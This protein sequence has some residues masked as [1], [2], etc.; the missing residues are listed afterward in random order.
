M[1]K[2]KLI[3]LLALLCVGVSKSWAGTATESYVVEYVGLTVAD[4]AGYDIWREYSESGW[5]ITTYTE[6]IDASASNDYLIVM[7]NG[8]DWGTPSV[9]DLTSENFNTYFSPKTITGYGSN[10]AITAPSGNQDGKITITYTKHAYHVEG[11]YIYSTTYTQSTN[12]VV[13][14]TNNE[15][16]ISLNLKDTDVVTDTV[17]LTSRYI[18]GT[19][20][21]ITR[22]KT[23][24][25]EGSKTEAADTDGD[26]AGT[27]AT[28]EYL[29]QLNTDM[30]DN[31]YWFLRTHQVKTSHLRNAVIPATVTIDGI[32]YTVTAIQKFGFNYSQNHQ[33]TRDLCQNRI[34]NPGTDEGI[35]GAEVWDETNNVRKDYYNIND[36][37]N[38]WLETVSFEAPEN[39]KYIGD[40]AF[41]S[42]VK[43]KSII[44][45]KNVEYLGT[46]VCS[47]CQALKD[48]LFQV[49]EEHKTKITVLK[50]FSFW[51]CTAIESLELPDG[52]LEIEGASYGA[53]L[54]YMEGLTLI[55]LP[56]TLRT[57]GPHFLCCASSLKEITIPAS[58]TYINGAAFHGCESLESVYLLGE[59]SAL[60]GEDDGGFP[61][62][63][64]NSSLCKEH[65]S[66]CTFYT[67][68][69]YLPSYAKDPTWR[70]ID[71]DG[72]DD[73]TTRTNSEGYT[74]TCNYG[75]YLKVIEPE[76]RDFV[77]GRWVTAIFP[78]GVTD[79]KTVFGEKTLVAR[80]SGQP[81]YSSEQNVRMYDVAFQLITG[82]DI[83]K[84][85]PVM[86][87][88][89]NTV[90]NYEMITMA[91]LADAN[92]KKDMTNEHVVD[93]L[94]AVDGAKI[95]MKGQYKDH[96]MLPWDFYFMYK[97]TSRD[98]DGNVTDKDYDNPAKF[99]RVPDAQ[100]AAVIRSTRCYWTI[101]VDGV[102]TDPT[103][104]TAKDFFFDNDVDGIE[105]VE[106]RINISGVYDLQGHKLNINENELPQGLYIVNGKK[107]VV[108]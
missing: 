59:A 48:V 68:P 92:F 41:Q 31:A 58:V 20:L 29:G 27:R 101:N 86:F 8:S 36:H 78:N 84:G 93:P 1:R 100:N 5:M 79:Y 105:N 99:Y 2:I 60:D 16:A 32:E 97:A 45:P 24:S 51:Y 64:E 108:K 62:F 26:D 40:Y 71:E 98:E 30:G 35:K 49:D 46:G 15:I 83:P 47:S 50:N 61:T 55:R 28:Y 73:G 72:K 7:K 19:Y 87:C 52:I 18:N 107:V 82:S 44:I 63:G 23:P 96:T 103:M 9:T 106:T 39:I 34:P 13:E 67:T 22:A 94:T 37:S 77:G 10:V 75:N 33:R 4:G 17:R 104:T 95:N 76:K 57:I 25:Q 102:K 12:N 14:L 56:N 65:V 66:G 80:P 91:N 88:P 85:T 81:T 38:Y 69:D 43:L 21:S 53:A 3:M 54:Q 11:D 6:G 70:L 74:I 90:N 89:E 42:C